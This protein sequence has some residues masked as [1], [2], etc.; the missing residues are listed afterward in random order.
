MRWRIR[1]GFHLSLP[2]IDYE[3]CPYCTTINVFYTSLEYTAIAETPQT[4]LVTL[5]TQLGGS[6]GMFISFSVFTL[7]EAVEVLVLL[8]H[9][10]ISNKNKKTILRT[11][12]KMNSHISPVSVNRPSSAPERARKSSTIPDRPVRVR[13]WIF[14]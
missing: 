11:T 14:I 8:L 7:F 13:S 6:L 9:A 12:A 1:F 5:F 2:Y 4:T 10:F 3:Y